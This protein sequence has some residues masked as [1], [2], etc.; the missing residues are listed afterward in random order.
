MTS[1]TIRSKIITIIFAVSLILIPCSIVHAD[2]LQ[3]VNNS[4]LAYTNADQLGLVDN[5]GEL[6]DNAVLPPE[7]NSD[8]NAILDNG[9]SSDATINGDEESTNEVVDEP[10]PVD[11]YQVPQEV[12]LNWKKGWHS[13]NGQKYYCATTG[14]IFTGWRKISK[15]Q[16]YFMPENGVMAKWEQNIDGYDYYFTKYG[17]MKK[18]WVKFPIGKR[19]YKSNGRMVRGRVKIGRKYYSFDPFNGFLL[20]GTYK[21]AASVPVLTFHRIV[22]DANKKQYYKNNQWVAS[23][24]D[25]SKQMEY[26]Y[27]NHYNV[28]TMDE[29]YEWYTGKKELP[30]KSVVLT[31]DDGHYEFQHLAVPILNKYGFAATM[32]VIGEH[33]ADETAAYDEDDHTERYLG[34]DA[35]N[36]IKEENPLI[37]FESHTFGLHHNIGGYYVNQKTLDELRDDFEIMKAYNTY[38]AWP[39]GAKSDDAIT[40]FVESGLKLAFGFGKYV[41][42]TRLDNPWDIN[43]IKINGQ[44]SLKSFAKKL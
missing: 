31:F 34:W 39:Y 23:V 29:Y 36:S 7:E 5:N 40:A 37:S 10:E 14:E 3:Y 44:I 11:P 2:D 21:Y 35:I 22:S 38:M 4:E 8:D 20:N 17:V 42:S 41:K 28:V 18:G 15:K 19:Y 24:S 30:K 12:Y 43:R 27:K 32:F 1:R 13:Y 6:N 9:S 25:F 26:L 16:Y 33:T